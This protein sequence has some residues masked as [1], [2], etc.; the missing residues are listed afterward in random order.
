ML[1]CV[2]AVTLAALLLVTSLG[3]LAQSVSA[4]S[5]VGPCEDSAAP[6]GNNLRAYAYHADNGKDIKNMAGHVTFLYTVAGTCSGT[7]G[8]TA[9]ISVVLP[10]NMQGGTIPYTVQLGYG[11]VNGGALDFYYTE[12]D[13]DGI[14]KPEPDINGVAHATPQAGDNYTFRIISVAGAIGGWEYQVV[15]NSVHT[16]A[17]WYGNAHGSSPYAETS[18]SAS[19]STTTAT[20]SAGSEP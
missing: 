18:W 3:L 10:V 11:I 4:T 17:T 6:A 13:D 20:P 9:P 16:T 12:N 5:Y 14:L 7:H 8:V 19:R 2:R 15:D 1:K